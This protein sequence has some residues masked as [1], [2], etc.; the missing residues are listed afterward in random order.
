MCAEL[1]YRWRRFSSSYIIWH[2]FSEAIQNRMCVLALLRVL[3]VYG[4]SAAS[5]GKRARSGNGLS[6]GKGSGFPSS[7]SVALLSQ[8]VWSLSWSCKDHRNN[9][10]KARF[11]CKPCS[12]ATFSRFLCRKANCAIIPKSLSRGLSSC[13]SAR[14]WKS[15]IDADFEFRI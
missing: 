4:M 11:R 2:I 5:K 15:D 14:H 12:P 3:N 7:A 8:S 10:S 6:S 9:S 1:K 13:P